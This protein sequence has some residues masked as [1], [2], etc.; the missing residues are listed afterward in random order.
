MT[1]SFKAADGRKVISKTTAEEIGSVKSF[2]VDPSAS[3]VSAIQIGGRR[4]NA[5][6]VDWTNVSA[7]GDDAVIV[8]SDDVARGPGEREKDAVKGHIRARGTR[9][10]TT[11][12]FDVGKVSDVTFDGATGELTG[13]VVNKKDLV[14]ADRLIS[15][16]SYA[17][18]ISARTD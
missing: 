13:I 8:N 18:V 11:D 14:S 9:V 16:G 7:F 10:L 6:L 3:R 2:V 15:L 17:L 4:A 12:G 5:E 1:Q